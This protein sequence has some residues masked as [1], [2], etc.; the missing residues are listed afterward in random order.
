VETILGLNDVQYNVIYTEDI[1]YT[2][3]AYD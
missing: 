2:D 3:L 1:F